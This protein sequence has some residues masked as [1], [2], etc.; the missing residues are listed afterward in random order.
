MKTGNDDTLNTSSS[1]IWHYNTHKGQLSMPP[2]GFEPATS[3]TDPP[4]ALV[5]DRSATGI[6]DDAINTSS[7][8]STHFKECD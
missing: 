8:K 4:L 3:A 5:L 2:E 7:N 1:S 6:G